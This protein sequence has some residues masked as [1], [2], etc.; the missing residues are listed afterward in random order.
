[1]HRGKRNKP[2][3]KMADDQPTC[4]EEVEARASEMAADTEGE[5][6]REPT[7]TDVAGILQTFM[8]QQEAQEVKL[9]HEFTR[10][11]QRFKLLQHQFQLLQMEVQARTS[12]F[13][14]PIAADPDLQETSDEDNHW[15]AKA[16][17]PPDNIREDDIEHFLVTFERIAAACRWPQTDWVFHLIPLL[18]GKARGAF[19]NV[20]ID[21]SL[22]Y[23]EVKKAILGKYDI[24]PETYKGSG[25]C[26]FSLEKAPKNSM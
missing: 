11:D 26:M 21:E 7:L 15:K 19:V 4:E 3:T 14:E 18:T 5:D 20:D 12:P 17:S 22:D 23:S 8:G 6:V 9:K 13:P 10:Q 24:N 1:M 16:S 25:P 2:E